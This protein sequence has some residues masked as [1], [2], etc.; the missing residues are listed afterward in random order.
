M[1]ADIIDIWERFR[2]KDDEAFSM[3]FETCAEYLYRYGRK[4]VSDDD[5]VRDC[6]QD[7]FIKLYN[8]RT[9]LSSTANPKSYLLLSMKNTIIDAL[10]KTRRMMYV[11]PDDLPFIAEVYYLHEEDAPEAIVTATGRKVKQAME[12]LNARQKEAIY[13]RLQLGLSYD[14]VSRMLGINYQS[15]RNLIHRSITKIRS[16][17]DMPDNFDKNV[18]SRE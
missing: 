1:K 3:L 15:A 2:Q 8:N 10:C 5:F 7:L 16:T 18:R 17:V 11:S 12:T 13:L 9:S 4:F 6:V 14:E